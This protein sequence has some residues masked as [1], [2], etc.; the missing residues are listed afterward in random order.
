MLIFEPVSYQLIS[1]NPVKG[2]EESA[3]GEPT[4]YRQ[5]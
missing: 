3:F 1:S 4:G 2:G 5:S